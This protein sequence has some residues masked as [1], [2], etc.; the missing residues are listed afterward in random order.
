MSLKALAFKFYLLALTAVPVT[1]LFYS[2]P[3][4]A[5]GERLFSQ[6]I[7]ASVLFFLLTDAV[8]GAKVEQTEEGLKVEQW[9]ETF[10]AY[11]EVRGCY[12]FYLPPLQFVILTTERRFPLKLLITGDALVGPRRSLIQDGRLALDVKSKMRTSVRG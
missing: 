4:M 12:S 10:I 7:A 1:W 11:R 9:V 8:F 6:A 3:K 5:S 2:T